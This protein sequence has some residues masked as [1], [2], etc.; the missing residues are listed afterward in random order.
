V[1]SL[2]YEFLGAGK[3]GNE[4]VASGIVKLIRG[5]YMIKYNHDT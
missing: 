5:K 1:G 4:V 3:L 2:Q